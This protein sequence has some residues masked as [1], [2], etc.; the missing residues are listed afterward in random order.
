MSHREHFCGLKRGNGGGTRLSI[1]QGKLAEE[2]TGAEH[3]E[4]LFA[5]IVRLLKNLH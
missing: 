1:D 3:A 5:A 4:N 2:F